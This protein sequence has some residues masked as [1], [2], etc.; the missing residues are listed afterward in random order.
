MGPSLHR[1]IMEGKIPT[2]VEDADCSAAVDD[3]TCISSGPA[4]VRAP[5]NACTESG[6]YQ[7]TT[8]PCART[9]ALAA[10]PASVWSAGRRPTPWHT[11]SFAALRSGGA[12]AGCWA[13]H[14]TVTVEG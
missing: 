2:P 10:R 6:N 8:A 7:L 9:L 5:G 1:D 4:T 12:G 13:T 11:S 14:W 3:W